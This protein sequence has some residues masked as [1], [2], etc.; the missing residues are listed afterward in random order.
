[1]KNITHEDYI[2]NVQALVYNHADK[3][4]QDKLDKIKLVYGAGHGQGAR[5]MTIYNR[6]QHNAQLNSDLVEVCAMGEENLTQLAGTTVHE[7]AHVLAG[8]GSGHDG[9]WKETC[10]KLGLRKA[11]AAGM[12]YN[13]ANFAP[14]L[15]YALVTLP[16]PTD[17]KPN[18]SSI[19]PITGATIPAP[20]L[21]GC[22]LG[23]GTRG[24][25]SRGKG[26]GSR[27]RLYICEC[28]IKVR[29]SRDNFDATCNI[30]K[31]SFKREEKGA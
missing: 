31:T 5:G 21:R 14:W 24:G 6:W 2:K 18:R 4:A 23:I 1:M 28:G 9:T 26:S 29:V 17:G 19:N 12:K 15:R 10:N 13:L 25:T 27:L 22:T 16:K 30:C 20:K 7:L 11:L 8:L 3:E